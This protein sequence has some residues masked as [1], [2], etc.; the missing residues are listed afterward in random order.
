MISV[1]DTV[2]LELGGWVTEMV[3]MFGLESD[4][5]KTERTP[6]G[7]VQLGWSGLSI[8]PE[9]SAFVVPLSELRDRVREQAK[10]GRVELGTLGRMD[11]KDNHYPASQ[12]FASANARFQR[13]VVELSAKGAQ[14]K[15]YLAACDYVRDKEL[16][17]LGIYLE[18]RDGLPA[19]I[20]PLSQS[21]R[22]ERASR[23]AAAASKAAAKEKAK[24]DAEAADR[25]KA[26]QGKL[27]HLDMFR[28]SEFSAWDAE[29]LPTHDA[30]GK[31]VAKSRGK[32]LRKDWERQ[33]KLHEAWKWAAEAGNEQTGADK[34]KRTDSGS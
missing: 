1:S 6:N 9:A 21:L 20:R 7:N 11:D 14:P 31:E 12:P 32:K 27:S 34:T 5:A 4:D 10:A 24:A 8:P 3:L 33:R 23:D 19:L 2:A 13:K 18:D 25:K 26:E 15:D 16:W 22:E 29:G 30:E 28:T 17:D